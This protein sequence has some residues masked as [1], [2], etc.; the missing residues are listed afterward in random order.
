MIQYLIY[1]SLTD[2][3]PSDASYSHILMRS[4]L[5]NAELDVTGYLHWEDRI[6]HQWIEGP[7][8]ML[9]IVEQ[10]ILADG[11]H[12]DVTILDRGEAAVREF[13]G[14]SMAASASEVSSLFNFMASSKT[15]SSDHPAH[16][17]SVLRF[18]KQQPYQ[19]DTVTCYDQLTDCASSALKE[20]D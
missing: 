18:M 8:E 10:I 5:R 17:Q 6:F 14:W 15:V 13:D 11:M 7:A 16:A 20:L 4:R 19:A 2:L 3:T 1:R 9:L 12:R